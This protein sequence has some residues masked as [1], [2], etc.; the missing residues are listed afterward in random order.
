MQGIQP[1]AWNEKMLHDPHLKVL[2][3][4][5]DSGKVFSG[6]YI[7]GGVA[8]TYHDTTEYFG[9]VGTFTSFPELNTIL[10]KV[11]SQETNSL[12]TIVYNQLRFDL[13]A[14]IC[15]TSRIYGDYRKQRER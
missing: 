5:A 8:I 10:R 3:Y 6:T 4:E 13:D 1:K 11:S 9:C 7:T 15:G 12:M 2:W 14:A